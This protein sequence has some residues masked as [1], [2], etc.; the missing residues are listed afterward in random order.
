M[1]QFTGWMMSAGLVFV[2]SAA[3][4][5]G[6]A[7]YGAPRYAVVSDFQGPYAAMPEAGP[8]GRDYGPSLLPPQEVYSVLRDNGFS[9]LAIP[10][11]RG[12]VYT[13]AVIDRGGEDGQLVIDARNG[14][15]L[16]FMP[17]YRMGDNF[18]EQVPDPYYGPMGPP[19]SPIRGGP[20]PPAPIP[21]LASRNPSSVPLPKASPPR[22]GEVR[23]LAASPAAEPA[24]QQSAT[25]PA[26][27]ADASPG[28]ATTVGQAKP[29]A[30]PMRPTQP[31]PKVQ[32][33]D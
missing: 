32:G 5:Q 22:A 16:R 20:R 3:N 21:H 10:H 33:L 13:V 27:P 23:P 9:P 11:Q 24:P 28:A 15:I 18:N 26:K 12:F 19:A 29:D 4:A 7:P 31:M 8:V 30:P 14:R 6:L 17:A 1:K 2:A 25:V